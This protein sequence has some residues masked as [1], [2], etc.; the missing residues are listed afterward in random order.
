MHL[1]SPKDAVLDARKNLNPK[2]GRSR[3]TLR[4][5]GYSRCPFSRYT[6]G[7][8]QTAIYRACMKAGIGTDLS[9]GV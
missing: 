2:N 1:F 9:A 8:Y 7:S 3:R 4:V 5:S 6:R